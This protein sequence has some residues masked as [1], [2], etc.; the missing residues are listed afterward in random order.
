MFSSHGFNI[1]NAFGTAVDEGYCMIFRPEDSLPSLKESIGSLTVGNKMF[2]FHDDAFPVNA[3][4]RMSPESALLMQTCDDA[5]YD[6]INGGDGVLNEIDTNH[7]MEITKEEFI[8]A[9][10]YSD[11]VDDAFDFIS[12]VLI[13][14]ELLGKPKNETSIELGQFFHIN[15]G[16]REYL[17]TGGDISYPWRSILENTIGALGNESPESR[18]SSFK[19]ANFILSSLIIELQNSWKY[20][21]REKMEESLINCDTDNTDSLHITKC[22]NQ[23]F[24]AESGGSSYIPIGPGDGGAASLS[25]ESIFKIPLAYPSQYKPEFHDSRLLKVAKCLVTDGTISLLEALVSMGCT[26]ENPPIGTALPTISP[27]VM[28]TEMPPKSPTEMPTEMPTEIPTV[29]PTENDS[30]YFSYT[31]TASNMPLSQSES[32]TLAP[33]SSSGIWT[34]LHSRGSTTSA[35]A[36]AHPKLW[37]TISE[38]MSAEMKF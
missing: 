18:V 29:M 37:N 31:W 28:P 11:N 38:G 12:S 7:D 24:L 4:A 30:H 9:N 22:A 21:S 34:L 1:K 20:P 27:T 33:T 6:A 32:R 23:V 5:R 36:V 17:K 10:K 26:D 14:P 15:W 13:Q 25:D 35:V 2:D 19:K 8:H 3:I 16:W